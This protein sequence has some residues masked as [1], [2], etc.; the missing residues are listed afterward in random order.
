MIVKT[1]TSFL[2]DDTDPELISRTNGIVRALTGNATYPTP[3]PTLPVVTTAL[4]TFSDAVS[5]ATGGG[6]A[7][8]AAKR[9]ARVALQALL[10]E[11]ATYVQLNCKGDLTKLLSSGFPTQ[12]PSRT[13]VGVLPAPAYVVV[14]LGDRS[15][16]L[17]T[18]TEPLSGASIYNWRAKLAAAPNAPMIALQ[19]T[20]A[21]NTFS[22]LTPGQVYEVDVN[23]VG[24]AGPSDWS[25]P[26]TQMVV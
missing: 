14:T 8:T 1:S 16:E 20:A 6:V 18:K 24:A 26:V 15:G 2:N 5:E 13:P 11:L 7:L 3:T 22:G 19:T 4:T 21:S 25:D 9:Q 12:K 23:V 17:R 10:R